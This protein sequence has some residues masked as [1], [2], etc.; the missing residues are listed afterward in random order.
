MPTRRTAPDNPRS[1]R[2]V[3]AR[4]LWALIAAVVLLGTACGDSDGDLVLDDSTDAADAADQAAPSVE[5]VS[6]DL[7]TVLEDAGLSTVATAV[8]SIDVSEIVGGDE[9]T[10]FA[11]NDEAFQALDAEAAADL[12]A[13]PAELLDVLRNHVVDQRIDAAALAD[14][15]DL[16]TVEGSTLAVDAG[17]DTVTVGE[18]VIVESDI[19]VGDGVVH[20]IDGVLLPG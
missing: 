18:A 5:A 16:T 7:A 3:G 2:A 10:F 4:S 15:A 12:L 1:S 11:P 20:V 9:F 14:M 6:D 8:R 17:G 19:A 13:D